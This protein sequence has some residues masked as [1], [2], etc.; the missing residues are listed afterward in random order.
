MAVMETKTWVWE[1]VNEAMEKEV[2]A[3]DQIALVTLLTRSGDRVRWWR[4][5]FE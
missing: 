3:N 4:E 2:M 1:G 5:H